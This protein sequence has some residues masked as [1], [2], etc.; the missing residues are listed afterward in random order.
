MNF[1]VFQVNMKTAKVITTLNS[2]EN[3]WNKR[4]FNLLI[5]KSMNKMIILGKYCMI[6][7]FCIVT[8]E[9]FLRSFYFLWQY[10]FNDISDKWLHTGRKLTNFLFTVLNGILPGRSKSW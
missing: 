4:K 9:N 3:V 7:G 10:T 8:S 1:L 6:A 5:I 2:S